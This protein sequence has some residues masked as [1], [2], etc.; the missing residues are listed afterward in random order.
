MIKKIIILG[1]IIVLLVAIFS[2]SSVSSTIVPNITSNNDNN[3]PII[4]PDGLMVW[5]GNKCRPKQQ[6][7]FFFNV[8]DPDG[9]DVYVRFDWGDG[10]NSGWI[11]INNQEEETRHKW[12]K[13]GVYIVT[14]K[15]IDDPDKD[16]PDE[17]DGLY[18]INPDHLLEA[19]K[20]TVK[21]LPISK[22]YKNGLFDSLERYFTLLQ[23]LLK[24]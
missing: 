5:N 17:D 22:L 9:D 23:H 15:A 4:I 7:I 21:G 6:K 10:S 14:A 24:L 13:R 12:D 11:E 16:G 8:Y 2:T 3:P 18:A 1:M 20:I 19:L